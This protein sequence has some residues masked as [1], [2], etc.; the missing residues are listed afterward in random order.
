MAENYIDSEVIKSTVSS[1]IDVLKSDE[2]YSRFYLDLELVEES[3]NGTVFHYHHGMSLSS[4]GEF[5]KIILEDLGEEGVRVEVRSECVVDQQVIDWGKNREN[6]WD[7]IV[8]IAER[9][10]YEPIVTLDNMLEK[11]KGEARK[12]PDLSI[13]CCNN[14]GTRLSAEYLFCPACGARLM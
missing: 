1:I 12:E 7:I 6:T 11:V 2:F 5:I 9:V 10:K 13:N 8:F 4:W 14:C 3:Y